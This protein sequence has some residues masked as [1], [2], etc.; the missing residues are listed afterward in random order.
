MLSRP[1]NSRR[2]LKNR[3]PPR[4]DR[5]KGG[6]YSSA[7]YRIRKLIEHSSSTASSI[8]AVSLLDAKPADSYL[9]LTVLT[10]ALGPLA[11]I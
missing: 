11:K 10:C 8:F 9:V 2:R 6:H 4:S 5:I 1:S 3:Y 7:L